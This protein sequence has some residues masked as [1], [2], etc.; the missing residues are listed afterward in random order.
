MGPRRE[1]QG[2]QSR[3]QAGVGE[4]RRGGEGQVP[5]P[6]RANLLHLCKGRR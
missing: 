6:H 5:P 3:G 1:A 2:A 4:G